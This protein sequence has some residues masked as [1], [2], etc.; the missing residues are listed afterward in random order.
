MHSSTFLKLTQSQPKTLMNIVSAVLS[1]CLSA[2]AIT[3]QAQLCVGLLRGTSSGLRAEREQKTTEITHLT[4]P[5]KPLQ[6]MEEV[7]CSKSVPNLFVCFSPSTT[8]LWVVIFFHTC[9]Y[10]NYLK[11]FSYVDNGAH[12]SP[13]RFLPLILF[14]LLSSWEGASLWAVLSNSDSA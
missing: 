11:P 6:K 7:C 2:A 9:A 4:P 14:H 5:C 3:G 12:P 13:L 10:S 1:S 8:P